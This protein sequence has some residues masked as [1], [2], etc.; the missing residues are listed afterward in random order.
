MGIISN[1]GEAGLTERRC[2]AVLWPLEE[3]VFL[4]RILTV[5]LNTR[6]SILLPVESHYRSLEPRK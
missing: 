5:S 3:Q 2:C 6:I 4:G 1:G